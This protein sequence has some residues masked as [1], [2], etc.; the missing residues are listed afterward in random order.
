M[1]YMVLMYADPAST[2]GLDLEGTGEMLKGVGLATRRT[3]RRS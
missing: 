1:K 2:E 3:R